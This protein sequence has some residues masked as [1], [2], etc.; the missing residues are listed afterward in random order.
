MKRNLI[1]FHKI[2]FFFILFLPS[3][4]FAFQEH[5]AT[6]GIF[7]HLLGHVCFGSSMLWLFFMIRKSSFWEKDWWK[8]ISYGALV[9]AFWN[10]TTFIGHVIN[11]FSPFS[12]PQ[13]E[14]VEGNLGFLIWYFSKLDNLI[15][16]FAMSLFYIGLKRLKGSLLEK[17]NE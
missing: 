9:L 1:I 14:M 10:V 12:C 8:A 4:S 3:N 11:P 13:I 15:C 2:S 17:D 16:I 6:E 7:I 5:G